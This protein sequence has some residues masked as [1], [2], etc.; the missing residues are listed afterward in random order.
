MSLPNVRL[1]RK[2]TELDAFT[3]GDG[4]AE[5]RVYDGG[6]PDVHHDALIGQ[7]LRARDHVGQCAEAR[8]S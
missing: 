7:R 5:E 1:G 2:I 8:T 4:S 6:W 3:R